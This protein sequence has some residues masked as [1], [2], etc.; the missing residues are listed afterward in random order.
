MA[1]RMDRGDWS[2]PLPQP[3]L[4]ANKIRMVPPAPS[5]GIGLSKGGWVGGGG[6][7]WRQ[8]DLVL[9]VGEGW[10]YEGEGARAALETDLRLAPALQGN[11]G[12]GSGSAWGARVTGQRAGTV[13]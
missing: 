7:R 9:L 10:G 6:G 11:Q 12:G 1:R 8:G 4:Y 3:R 13:F 5:Q 2:L